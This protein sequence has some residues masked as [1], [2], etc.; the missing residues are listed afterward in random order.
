VLLR[1]AR[2][3]ARDRVP[4]MSAAVAFYSLL[5]LVPGLAALVSVYGLA[6]NPN[7]VDS[8]VN[9]WLDAAPREVRD[10]VASQL[11][12]ITANAGAG[13]GV[14]IIVGIVIALWT[15]SSGMNHLMQAINV[16]YDE[17]EGRGWVRRRLLAVVMTI[18]AMT[19][20]LF[21]FVVIAIVPPLLSRAGLGAF[22]RIT[23]DVVRWI[24][25]L[26]GM[27][28]VLTVLYR[29]APDRASPRWEWISPGAVA[30]TVL[31]L[32]ASF[33]FSI[34]TANF[35][36]YNETYGSLGA[37]V[38]S[39]LWLFITAF[40]VIVGAEL[41]AELEREAAADAT[42]AATDTAVIEPLSRE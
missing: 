9:G 42:A 31:W 25:L 30:A 22:T 2:E 40:A 17:S 16:A 3:V 41:N 32:V 6:A 5:A 26:V 20:L 35:A 23:G 39:M 28:A 38:I 7:E 21:A 29:F 10:L 37:I 8:Q 1:T 13:V 33:A 11:R 12:S 15:A 36:K 14:G 34:Y 4:M 27:L 18:G 24:A 19:F